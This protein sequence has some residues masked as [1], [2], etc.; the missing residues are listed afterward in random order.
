MNVIAERFGVTP[1]SVSKRGRALGLRPIGFVQRDLRREGKGTVSRKICPDCHG[2]GAKVDE[3]SMVFD[4]C[5]T[6][7]GKGTV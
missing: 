1:S 6:C 3:G 5:G 7:D 2:A 4:T